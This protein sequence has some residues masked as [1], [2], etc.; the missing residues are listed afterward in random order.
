MTLIFLIL[1]SPSLVLAAGLAASNARFFLWV[2]T[3]PP[4]SL[5]LCLESLDIPLLL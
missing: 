5:L 2:A 4:V 3:L 1:F